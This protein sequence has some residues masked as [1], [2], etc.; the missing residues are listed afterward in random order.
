[1]GRKLK[2]KYSG[3]HLK[4]LSRRSR[5]SPGLF[6][7]YR[8]SRLLDTSVSVRSILKYGGIVLAFVIIL[9]SVFMLGRISASDDAPDSVQKSTQL[10]GQTRQLPK[11][12]A[13]EV[14]SAAVTK[15]V[16]EAPGEE[17]PAPS[18]SEEEPSSEAPVPE[19]IVEEVHETPKPLPPPCENTVA[20][21]DYAYRNVVV[22]ISNFQRELK[23][24]NWGTLTSLKLTVTNNETCTI[25]NPTKAKLKLNPKYKGSVWWDDDVFLPD[26]FQHMMPGQ[27]VSEVVP[28]HASYSD[29]YSE[30]DFKL[31]VF[32]DYDIAM[33]TYK[34]YITL[35]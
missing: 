31:T 27:T 8:T 19:T 26:S 10:S 32:D 7:S 2:S 9:V 1:L 3:I 35:P 34:N 6:S 21:F 14:T 23:G 20:G 16:E 5:Y 33:G 15:Q 30:K 12:T 24:D 28:V 11:E 17:E 22:D 13:E 4:G 18:V 25:I 29:I